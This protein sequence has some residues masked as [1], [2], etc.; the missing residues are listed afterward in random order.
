MIIVV[1]ETFHHVLLF[2]CFLSWVVEVEV[3]LSCGL[4]A[5]NTIVPHVAAGG[6]SYSCPV[7]N[8]LH[9]RQ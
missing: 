1:K 8:S 4:P 9:T 5:A 6:T 7:I 3:W 2:D